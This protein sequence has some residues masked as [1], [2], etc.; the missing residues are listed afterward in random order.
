MTVMLASA[1]GRTLPEPSSLGVAG[2]GG[3]RVRMDS[4]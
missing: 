1:A 2:A 3:R 4:M